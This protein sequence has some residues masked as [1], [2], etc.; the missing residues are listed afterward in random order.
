[1]PKNDNPTSWNFRKDFDQENGPQTSRSNSLDH[2]QEIVWLNGNSTPPTLG[3]VS[4]ASGES[5]LV[6][7]NVSRCLEAPVVRNLIFSDEMSF[8]N[9]DETKNPMF[10]SAT[11]PELIKRCSI[12][13][14]DEKSLQNHLFCF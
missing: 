12:V 5:T 14:I 2:H 8:C 4:I 11:Q 7:L 13:N 6:E 10:S 1:M 9:D 3:V